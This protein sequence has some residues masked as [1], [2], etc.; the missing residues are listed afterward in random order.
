MAYTA[1]IAIAVKGIQDVKAL[2]EKIEEAARGVDKFN[3]YAKEAFDGDFVRSIRNLNAALR[4]SAEA[5]D[6]AA[7]G[8]SRAVDAASAYIAAEREINKGLEERKRLLREVAAQEAAAAAA[9]MG[10]QFTTG[11]PKALPA[12]GQTGFKGEVVGGL[13]GGARAALQNY[14]MLVN[15]AGRLASRTQDQTDEALRFAQALEQQVRPLSQVDALYAG[16]AQQAAQMQRVKALPD[17]AMLNATG[18]GIQ[19]LGTAQDRYNTELKEST[20]RLQELD[21][22]EQSRQRRAAKLQGIADYYAG[23]PSVMGSAGFGAPIPAGQRPKAPPKRKT[24]LQTPGVM[25]AILGAGFPVLFGGGPGSVLGGAAGGL[26]GGAMGG[27]AGMALS[28]ALSAVGQQLDEMVKKFSD[29]G[30][31]IRRLDVEALRNSYIFVNKEL[32]ITLDNLLKAGEYEQARA[33]LAAE[34]AKQTGASVVQIQASNNAM[35]QLQGAWAEVTRAVGGLVSIIA[36]PL[37]NGIAGVLKVVSMIAVGAS[38]VI[39]FTRNIVDSTIGWLAKLLNVEKLY[40]N[41]KN[42]IPFISEE[43]EKIRAAAEVAIDAGIVDLRTR[44]KRLDIDKQIVQGTSEEARISQIE[45]ERKKAYLQIEAD[46]EKELKQINADSANLTAQQLKLKRDIA[47][48]NAELHKQE[49]ALT[50]ERAAQQALLNS[51]LSYVQSLKDLEASRNQLENTQ[52]NLQKTRLQNELQRLQVQKDFNLY[53]NQEVNSVNAIQTQ[54]LK[55]AALDRDNVIRN[56]DSAIRQAKLDLDMLNTRYQMGQLSAKEYENRHKILQNTVT[57]AEIEKDI[58]NEVYKQATYI[59][60]IERKQAIVAEY[61]AEYAR[62]TEKATRALEEQTNTLSNRASLTAAISQAVQTI[63]NIEIDA[64][65][66]ELERTSSTGQRA[67]ILERI[68]ELEVQNAE[69]ALKATR[70]QIQAEL[71]RA[72]AAYRTVQLKYEE[73]RAVVQIAE[74]EGVVNRAHYAA[75]EAQGSALRIAKDNLTTA[76]QIAQWQWKAA[77]AVFKAAVDAAKLKKEMGGVA[78]AAGQFAGNMERAAGAMGTMTAAPFAAMG[79]AEGIQD[80]GLKMQAQKVW[81]DAEKFAATKGI[82]SIQADILQ[83]AR[84]TI[85]QIAARDYILRSKSASSTT[86]LPDT[87]A[88]AATPS[89]ASPTPIP[90]T[91][92]LATGLSMQPGG[93]AGTAVVDR[94]PT[95]NLQTGPVLQQD[96]GNKYVSL[97]DLEKILQDF[98]AVVFNN[99]RSTGGRRF[100]GVA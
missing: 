25:D 60:E 96:D 16:I 88:R 65:T 91:Q 39:S 31:A 43:Q 35:N 18:R 71:A 58:A 67:K 17:S 69:V 27:M 83:R 19:A 41:F 73:L 30:E 99:A 42:I 95:I 78:S 11:G 90:L 33:L 93:G 48:A 80:P 51:Y 34:A 87:T 46:L 36:T 74:A 63:N 20:E 81:Q 97:G 57:Q 8:T 79:G 75:L 50:A 38:K 3:N 61:A 49:A 47:N 26:A 77:D 45:A 98:A 84:D 72:Q 2:R 6:K 24:G 21:R 44:K 23:D 68:Y 82:A 62:N 12:A 52:S 85:A 7:L 89:P 70:A 10:M 66:R 59:I 54:K 9:R 32:D 29:V 22:L 100:Q 53:L 94:M 76:G 13:G 15:A 5:F 86:V 55:I 1:S 37:L 4:E 28:V 64:L 92:P 56:Q 14:E 40:K